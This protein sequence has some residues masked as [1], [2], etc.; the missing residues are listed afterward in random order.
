MKEWKYS[1]DAVTKEEWLHR[2]KKDLKEASISSLQSQWWEDEI[3]DPFHHKEDVLEKVVLPDQ[4]FTDPP[5]MMEWINT[6]VKDGKQ[7][8]RQV[9]NSLQYGAQSIVFELKEPSV[10]G[11][12]N[13]L[14]GVHMNMVD[15]SLNI[16]SENEKNVSLVLQS[17]PSSV[18]LRVYRHKDSTHEILNYLLSRENIDASLQLV[19]RISSGKNWITD[20]VEMFLAIIRDFKHHSS[21]HIKPDDFFGKCRIMIDAESSF[22]KQIIQMRVIQMVWLNIT[23]QLTNQTSIFKSPIEYHIHDKET[24]NPDQYLISS[25]ASSLAASL[26][27]VKAIC[28]HHLG[29]EN[30]PDYYERINR[31]IQHLL[32]LESQMYKGQDPLSGSYT[33][34]FYTKKWTWAI[35]DKLP[36]A[37]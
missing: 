3:I 35:I 30:I 14:E 19:Y 9:N 5:L 12:E 2:I 4:Y 29:L 23:S 13:W 8:A 34:D 22:L 18:G 7:I 1:F 6:S 10:T 11:L 32:S 27:G 24:S 37:N 26:T 28:I 17:L 31:N 36:A 21:G 33:I 25:S 20:A 16:L 15:I